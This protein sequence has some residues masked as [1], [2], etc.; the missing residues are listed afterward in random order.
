MKIQKTIILFALAMSVITSCAPGTSMIAT[1]LRLTPVLSTREI[2]P[3][4][5]E[6]P[7]VTVAPTLTQQPTIIPT[8]SI[9]IANARLL[10]LLA[11][12]GGCQL[13]CLWGITPGKST[14]D[15]ARAI[16]EP[17]ASISNVPVGFNSKGGS[18]YPVYS[19][20]D[21]MLFAVAGVDA[22]SVS[23]TQIVTEIYFRANEAQKIKSGNNNDVSFPDIFDS[24]LFG[25]QVYPYTLSQVL[26]NQGMPTSVLISTD[27]GPDRGKNV[28]AFY[29]VLVYP[30]TG[31]FIVYSTYKTSVGKNIRGCPANAHIEL[32]LFP[33]GEG[34]KFPEFLSQT[35][36]AN[37]WPIIPDDPVW[38]P[39]EETTSM[40]MEQFYET[41]RQP[42]DRCIETPT[43]LWPTP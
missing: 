40:T 8:L 20:G 28:P 22:T 21:L 34:D 25:K 23:N 24:T 38:K 19:E 10:E 11:D 32:E 42:T 26:S 14:Y 43:K 29:V 17:L 31:L 5:T 4:K 41:F 3:T 1:P 6:T 9:E 37:V 2:L 15:E 13:P 36:W 39:L 35:D 16:L 7:A 18:I 27:A 33:S 30:D 12:N